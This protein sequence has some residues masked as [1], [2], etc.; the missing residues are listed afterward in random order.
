MENDIGTAKKK[1][2]FYKIQ[3]IIDFPRIDE[4]MDVYVTFERCYIQNAFVKGIQLDNLEFINMV[5]EGP[6]AAAGAPQKKNESGSSTEGGANPNQT[7][8]DLIDD[9][10]FILDKSCKRALM[11][12]SIGNTCSIFNFINEMLQEQ[13]LTTFEIRFSIFTDLI[14]KS[15]DSKKYS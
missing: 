1:D 7:I 2:N 10:C 13:V 15:D 5:K 3:N 6:K 8:L 11:S 14:R 12:L 4:L 9:F